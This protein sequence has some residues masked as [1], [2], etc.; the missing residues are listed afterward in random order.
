[1]N[2]SVVVGRARLG[3]I[4]VGVIAVETRNVERRIPA[5]PGNPESREVIEPQAGQVWYPDSAYKT[6]TAIR[7]FN[8]GENL[9]LMIFANWRGFSGGTRDM[10]GEILKFGALI[11]DALV[12]YKHPVSIYIPP[13]GE[14]RGGSWVVIDPA[15]NPAVMEMYAD[16]EARGGILEP[17]GVVEVKFRKP[18]RVELMHRLDQKLLSLDAKLAEAS[19]TGAAEIKGQIAA[20]EG[21]LEPLYT[22]V[23]CEFADLHDRAG[24]MKAVGAIR[25]GLEWKTSREFFYWRI[26]RRLAEMQVVRDVQAAD[27]ALA[28]EG[29]RIM[30]DGWLPTAGGDR[31]AAEFL[32]KTPPREEIRAVRRAAL[33]RQIAELKAELGEPEEPRQEPRKPT[34]FAKLLGSLGVE[35]KSLGLGFG[36]A[37]GT[38]QGGRHEAPVDKATLVVEVA[39][40]RRSS[41]TGVSPRTRSLGRREGEEPEMPVTGRA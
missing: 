13:G 27:P 2:L 26:R 15:I 23:A 32:E 5:D 40:G 24:R 1:M 14:L 18:Q 25:E 16:V 33:R 3:G 41:G 22:Q 4:P 29:V 35:P 31:A 12:E 9:P 6:A 20:R 11:V 28:L 30:V 7:D 19:G 8:R 37:S 38:S 17:A 39:K 36:G 10:F 34:C 21:H